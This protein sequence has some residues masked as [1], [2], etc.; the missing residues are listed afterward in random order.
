MHWLP[1]VLLTLAASTARAEPPRWIVLP[2]YA[3]NP[4]PQDPTLLRLSRAVGVA[5]AAAADAEVRVVSRELREEHCR[6]AGHRCPDAIARILGADRVIALVLTDDFGA[7][8]ARVHE[9]PDRTFDVRVECEWRGGPKCDLEELAE[10]TSRRRRAPY[11][12]AAVEAAWA[13]LR[14]RIDRCFSGAG[15]EPSAEAQLTFRLR[16][17]G[18]PIEVRVDPKRLQRRRAYGCA[19]RVVESLRVPPFV[20]PRPPFV[21]KPIAGG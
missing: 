9:P 18:R 17:D 15:V 21:R 3:A 20:A 11:D 2:V 4:P 7:L 13:Q 16:E 5:V 14:P 8:E 19:A 12:P 6:D 10:A 1:I